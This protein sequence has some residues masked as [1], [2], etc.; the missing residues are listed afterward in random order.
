MMPIVLILV[1]TFHAAEDYPVKTL[2]VEP[3]QLSSMKGLI[4][5]D[6][7]GYAAYDEG[8]IPGAIRVDAAGWAK[9]FDDGKDVRAWGRRLRE[10]GL[11]KS[12]TVVVYDDN[13]NK[14][15]ARVWWILKYWGVEDVRLLHGMWTGWKSAGNLQ[16]TDTIK[17][18]PGDFE[19]T[20]QPQRLATMNDVLQAVKQKRASIVD[21]RTLEEHLGREKLSKH[22]GCIPGAH[23]LDWEVLI[24]PK[25]SRFKSPEQ[26]RVLFDQV[27]ID[28]KQPQI[29]HCQGG[30]RSSV[31]SFAL[32]LMGA[33]N[34]RNYHASWGEWGNSDDVPIQK[35]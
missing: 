25:T 14:D 17:S 8:H 29:A 28:L 27:D 35:K 31:M 13:K 26:L 9:Q 5:L 30:G 16:S 23:H 15:A 19:P 22:G 34:V 3:T 20:P 1:F 18:T 2:L 6:A 7:R 11:S 33:R 4:I 10:L 24:D 32:E 21:A 12:S